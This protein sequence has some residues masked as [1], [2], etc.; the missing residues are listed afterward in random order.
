MISRLLVNAAYA[1]IFGALIAW[2]AAAGARADH[3]RIGTEGSYRP[4]NMA[5]ANGH[6]TGFD[7]DVANA[8]CQKIGAQC[9][10][11]VQ[12]FDSLIPSLTRGGRFDAIFSSLSISDSRAK[13]IAFSVP[14]A[15]LKNMFVVRRDSPLAKITDKAALFKA[16]DGKRMGVENATT[17]SLY[18]EAHIPGAELHTYDTFDN[19]LMDLGNGRLDVAFADDATWDAYLANDKSGEFV[20]VPVVI[21]TSDDYATLGGGIAA[22]LPKGNEALR[23]RVNKAIC[24]LEADGTIRKFSI[25]WF[26]GKDVSM[27]CSADELK[28]SE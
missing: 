21:P 9:N 13:K 10:F 16:L 11:V 14:Y 8:V 5:D 22:G 28:A 20:Y 15:Q 7:A 23:K 19:L 2:S 24:G 3:L 27:Q 17:H 1:V 25:K 18:V 4:W 6:V 26:N 12:N